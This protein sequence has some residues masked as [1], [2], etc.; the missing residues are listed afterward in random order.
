MEAKL[1]QLQAAMMSVIWCEQAGDLMS[2]PRN[3]SRLMDAAMACG[4]SFEEPCY[5]TW[6]A[7]RVT[8]WLVSS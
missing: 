6:A 4:A 1:E 2:L 5:L 8:D 7:M 3:E